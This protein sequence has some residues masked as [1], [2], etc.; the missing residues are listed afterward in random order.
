[1]QAALALFEQ[2]EI[3]Y[4]PSSEAS[5]RGPRSTCCGNFVERLIRNHGLETVTITLRAIVES[6]GNEGELI[7]DVIGAICDLVC[8]HPRWIN[9]GLAFLEAMDSVSLAEVRRTAKRTGVQPLRD[10]IMTLVCVELEKILGPSKLPKPPKLVKPKPEP[11][12]PRSVTRIPEIEANIKLGLE[13][14]DLRTTTK[15]NKKFGRL[16]RQLDIDLIHASEVMRVARVYASKPAIWR[17]VSW[18]ALVR[19]SSPKMSP[20]VQK[21]IEAR[22]LAGQSVSAPEIHRAC[23]P[24]TAGSPKRRQADQ[25]APRIAA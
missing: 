12:P 3:E 15:C 23:G 24:L 10:A 18:R 7:A 5:R 1:M 11:K 13:L 20:A 19:L 8:T 4:I 16:R 14:L 9:S 25:L 21:G 22:I 2:L 17:A 6:H